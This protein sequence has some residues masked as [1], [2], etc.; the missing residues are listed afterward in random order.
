MFK[1]NREEE[2]SVEEES[3]S[4]CRSLVADKQRSWFGLVVNNRV[5]LETSMFNHVREGKYFIDVFMQSLLA[6]FVQMLGERDLF[7]R[8]SIELVVANA[9]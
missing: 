9:D 4:L 5:R 3:R 2:F 7:G 6:D 8:E 1:L